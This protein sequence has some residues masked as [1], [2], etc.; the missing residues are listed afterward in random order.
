V[1]IAGASGARQ[2][3]VARL[4]PPGSKRADGPFRRGQ[5]LGVPAERL[6][7]ELF[8][9]DEEGAGMRCASRERSRWRMAAR[10]C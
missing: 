4:N 9:T 5:L 10:C 7:I 8:G 3:T 6:E 1:L 2:G